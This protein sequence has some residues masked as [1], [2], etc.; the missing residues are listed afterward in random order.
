MSFVACPSDR[1][2]D[3]IMYSIDERNLYFRQQPIKSRLPL[4]VADRQTEIFDCRFAINKDTLPFL[5][6]YV[7]WIAHQNPGVSGPHNYQ[8]HLSLILIHFP[9]LPK[10]KTITIIIPFLIVSIILLLKF[11]VSQINFSCAKKSLDMWTCS[12]CLPA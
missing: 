10:N 8:K 2:T 6:V 7:V 12:M 11:Y 1:R 4:K 3:H 5:V 9:P